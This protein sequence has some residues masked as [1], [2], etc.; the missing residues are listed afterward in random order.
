MKK[1]QTILILVV[2]I[3]TLGYQPFAFAK[4]FLENSGFNKIN[5]NPIGVIADNLDL[6]KQLAKKINLSAHDFI[7]YTSDG[8]NC[9]LVAT[10]DMLFSITE[11]E[12][13]YATTP[14]KLTEGAVV[15]AIDVH[16]YYDGEPVVLLENGNNN[17]D[18]TDK[19]ITNSLSDGSDGITFTN[20]HPSS[21]NSIEEDGDNTN[22]YTKSIGTH[23]EVSLNKKKVSEF[24]QGTEISSTT[25]NTASSSIQTFEFSEF[26]FDAGYSYFLKANVLKGAITGVTVYYQ[27]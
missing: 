14:I 24:G 6:K 26:T 17:I 8:T 7:T 16:Y 5:Q 3:I 11:S 18:D 25:S 19:G 2:T 23:V 21:D 9:P 13:C 22:G 15:V 4:G 27:E 20:T 12:Y 1:K 10:T